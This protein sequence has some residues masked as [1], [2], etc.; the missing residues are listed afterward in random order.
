MN[1]NIQ[2]IDLNNPKAYETLKKMIEHSSAKLSLISNNSGYGCI[3][4]LELTELPD[5][6]F[7][8]AYE[9]PV[10]KMIIKMGFYDNNK[11]NQSLD[12]DF[13]DEKNPHSTYFSKYIASE[14]DVTK[15]ANTQDKV[16]NAFPHNQVTFDVA[17]VHLYKDETEY[18]PFLNELSNKTS[19]SDDACKSIIAIIKYTLNHNSNIKL[20]IIAMDYANNYINTSTHIIEQLIQL[21]SVRYPTELTNYCNA[22]ANAI[23]IAVFMR[24]KII[25]MDAH[26]G[27]FL[28]SIPLNHKTKRGGKYVRSDFRTWM[29]DA[30]CTIDDSYLQNIDEKYSDKYNKLTG[31]NYMND[32]NFIKWV[33]EHWNAIEGEHE[34]IPNEKRLPLLHLINTF[35]ITINYVI[36]VPDN[37]DEY[38]SPLHSFA[39]NIIPQLNVDNISS[40]IDINDLYIAELNFVLNELVVPKSLIKPFM[41]S[42]NYPDVISQIK[43][44]EREDIKKKYQGIYYY[45]LTIVP[46][47]R[48]E[49]TPLQKRPPQ[50]NQANNSRK[51]SRR[52]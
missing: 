15:E 6:Y 37:A 19:S 40:E 52:I 50:I 11:V 13:E 49:D 38:E 47:L 9:R 3:F 12:F 30:G 28:S 32:Y 20:G 22:Y 31:R 45:M 34:F 27:N 14:N 46:S 33:I 5:E 29:I 21:N 1:T 25:N 41:D 16:Y 26:K 36:V 42:I 51:K 7:I 35:I 43:K 48:T 23:M 17:C 8:D 18:N 39:E 44:I 10:T 2:R 4:L 24:L